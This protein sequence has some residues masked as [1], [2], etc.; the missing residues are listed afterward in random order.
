MKS[1]CERIK[2]LN[3]KKGDAPSIA[4]ELSRTTRDIY[5]LLD[6]GLWYAADENELIQRKEKEW[7][8]VHQHRN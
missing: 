6:D 3:A 7:G 5:S 8:A 1:D 2:Q 4:N